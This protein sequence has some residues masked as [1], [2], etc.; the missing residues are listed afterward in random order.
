MNINMTFLGQMISF[1]IL[2]W[3]TMKFIWPPLMAAIEERQQKIAEGLAAADQQP[4][5]PRAGAG[6]GQRRAARARAKANEIIEQAHQRAQP[7]HRPGQERRDRRRPTARRR[8][9]KPRSPPPPTA[10]GKTCASRCRRWPWPAPRSCS[11]ARSMPTPTRRC[12][13]NSP[14]RSERTRMSQALT[15]ARPYARAAFAHGARATARSP[16]WSQ[17]LG[18]AARV[19]ADPQVAGAAGQPAAEPGRRWSA[20]SRRMAP[21]SAF[22]RVPRRCWPTTAASPLLPEIAGLFDE[23]RAE[24][25]RVVKA[26]GHLGQRAAG[27]RAGRAQGRA[28]EA[29]RP[30]GRDRDGGRRRR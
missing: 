29:L 7:D 18:F 11:S 10:P 28:E 6:E 5:E 21:T 13:T 8:W 22:A 3:F 12:S 20:C 14:P 25:E 27:R 30:R 23:L 16:R 24:A 15:L 2:I 1:A 4:E 9:P 19:A 17:A 26:H